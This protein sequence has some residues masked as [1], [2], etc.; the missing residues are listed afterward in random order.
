[1]S[2]WAAWMFAVGVIGSTLPAWILFL[3]DWNRSVLSWRIAPA[4]RFRV[5]VSLVAVYELLL[6]SSFALKRE[7]IR[8][9]NSR[10]SDGVAAVSSIS[11]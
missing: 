6:V 2:E 1:M 3:P 4:W 9:A 10:R 5:L 7:P 11:P 8:V